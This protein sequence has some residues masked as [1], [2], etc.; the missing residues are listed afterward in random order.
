M[1]LRGKAQTTRLAFGQR[2]QLGKVA[3]RAIGRHHQQAEKRHEA[4][5]RGEVGHRV[6]AQFAVQMN[7]DGVRADM[8]DEQCV[9][10]GRGIAYRHRT[11]HP[12]TTRLVVDQHLLAEVV[13]QPLGQ[14]PCRGVC[15]TT[16]GKR[17]HQGQRPLRKAGCG[18]RCR[19]RRLRGRRLGLQRLAVPQ[20]RQQ[21][22]RQPAADRPYLR[23][24]LRP[25]MRLPVHDHLTEKSVLPAA[26]ATRHR[27]AVEFIHYH[28]RSSH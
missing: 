3:C 19:W 20:Q 12:A 24:R 17:H 10:I 13:R 8:T 1:A 26:T 11:G 14:Q 23:T 22:Q 9:A 4:A 18:Q 25:R 28:P 27:Q 2:H 21:Q 6:I 16:R 15:A 7:V 5:D